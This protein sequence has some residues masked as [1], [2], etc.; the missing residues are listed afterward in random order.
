M[1]R[2]LFL[3]G[4]A[5]ICLINASHAQQSAPDPDKFVCKDS[6]DPRCMTE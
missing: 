3:A 6:V 5:A 1:L 4:M 2:M